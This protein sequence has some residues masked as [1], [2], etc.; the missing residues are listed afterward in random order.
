ME[1]SRAELKT[2]FLD[3]LD[4]PAGPGRD[5][6]LAQACQGD[7]ALQARVEALIRAHDEAGDFLA[8]SAAQE[9]TVADDDASGRPPIERTSVRPAGS[10]DEGDAPAATTEGPG[11]RV[12]P[13]KILQE[14]GEGGMGAVFMAEQE[15]PIRRKVAL[16]L[17]KAGM[18][19]RQVIARFEAER[20]ALA[21]MDHP[22]IARV[23]DAGSTVERAAPSS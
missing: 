17:I 19:T 7:R 12:G 2:I 11:S 8:T 10:A 15:R 3:A 13:Y 16:K 20:Q 4:V 5:A 1:R 14:I 21:L 23:L 9:Q 22:N 18:D 6:Y